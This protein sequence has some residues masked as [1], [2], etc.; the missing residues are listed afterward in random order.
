MPGAAV[1]KSELRGRKVCRARASL[2]LARVPNSGPKWHF[3]DDRVVTQ[4]PSLGS[5][6]DEVDFP[7]PML[8]RSF[9]RLPARTNTTH[10]AASRSRSVRK[11]ETPNVAPPSGLKKGKVGEADPPPASPTQPKRTGPN[12]PAQPSSTGPSRTQLSA[13]SN[14][15]APA[16]FA[17]DFVTS[18]S[19]SK[20]RQTCSSVSRSPARPASSTVRHRLT[21]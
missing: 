10:R 1:A 21:R 17:R 5:E 14:D 4:P 6:S 13:A 18:P 3:R 16:T 8:K 19:F 15:E 9:L 7:R 2:N 12:G 20:A 11:R